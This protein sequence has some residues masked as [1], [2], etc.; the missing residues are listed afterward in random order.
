MKIVS[1][2]LRGNMVMKFC[3]VEI[4][5]NVTF[6]TERTFERIILPAILFAGVRIPTAKNV[7]VFRE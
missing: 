2:F 1:T 3:V 7:G 4:K 6:H 5:E